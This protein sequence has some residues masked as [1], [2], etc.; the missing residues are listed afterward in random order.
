MFTSEQ[1]NQ[2]VGRLSG[3]ERARVLIA[4]LMLDPAD[5]L[6]LD[7][8]TNP[9]W[10]FQRSKFWKKACWNFLARRFWLPRMTAICWIACPPWCSASTAA[11]GRSA[12]P[13]TRSGIYGWRSRNSRSPNRL[14]A[15][16]GPPPRERKSLP[17]LDTR[18]YEGMRK[19]GSRK[20]N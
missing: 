9:T 6:L 4:A 18:E 12:S 2:P 15:P 11:A 19:S 10:I 16:R 8:P 13:I 17:Y 1:L 5:V 14:Q 20:P 3:G 7:E